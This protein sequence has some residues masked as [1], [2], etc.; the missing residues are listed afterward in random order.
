MLLLLYGKET[1]GV[2]SLALAANAYLGILDMG[3]NTGAI[4][5]FSQWIK[6]KR[7]ALLDNVVR[8]SLSFYLIIGLLNLAIMIALSSFASSLFR[9]DSG[10]AVV[11]SQLLLLIGLFGVVNWAGS[12]LNQ[13]LIANEMIDFTQQIMIVRSVANAALVAITVWQK[14]PL[15]A[16]F[17]LFS[18]I[19][20]AVFLPYYLRL[21]SIKLVSSVIPAF[22]WGDFRVV[23]RYSVAIFAMSVFQFT[24]TQSRPIILGLFGGNDIGILAEYRI[25]EVFPL[26]IISIGGMLISIFLPK[27]SR[28][29]IEGN[30]EQIE[31]MSVQGTFL[32]SCIVALL[33]FPILINAKDLLTVYVGADYS[34]L[35]RWLILWVLTVFFYLHNSPVA[36]LVLATGKTRMLV[37]SS[38]IACVVSLC[39]NA[40]LCAF[41]GVGA[42]VVGYLVYI[43]IQMCFYYFYFNKKVLCLSS[44]R[45][46]S[47]FAVPALLSFSV[48]ALTLL[49]DFT[50]LSPITRMLLRSAIWCPLFCASAFIVHKHTPI[51][52]WNKN[53]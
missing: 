24:A 19:N 32:S 51:T 3:V 50:G 23:L 4:K 22:K 21:K 52:K 38:A 13:L 11:L 15:V 41:Y 28:L 5:Y 44:A 49:P 26:F 46:F 30:K 1:Y 48:S 12:V 42:A 43:V 8:T 16:Y 35:D 45:V 14:L 27:A 40:V 33:C 29:V 47:S 25:I 6:E 53:T 9:I 10:H 34:G 36:S 7:I 17:F 37:I 31:R 2:L 39:V 20:C 18:L